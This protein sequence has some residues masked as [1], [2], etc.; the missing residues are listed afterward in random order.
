MC[1]LSAHIRQKPRWWEKIH[2]ENIRK[3]WM[4]EAKE[5]QAHLQSWEQL[6]N[7]MVRAA[8]LF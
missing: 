5:Q 7:N 6:T 1:H 4:Q 3:K 8:P 2:D